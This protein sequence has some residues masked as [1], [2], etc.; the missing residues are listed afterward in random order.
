M[1]EEQ[2]QLQYSIHTQRMLDAR[3]DPIVAQFN[4]E[5]DKIKK[6][7]GGNVRLYQADKKK[8]AEPVL[9]GE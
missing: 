2:E 4:E 8:E 7:Y 9:A 5:L 3:P 6:T 1:S